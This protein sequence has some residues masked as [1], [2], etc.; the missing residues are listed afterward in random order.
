MRFPSPPP[1]QQKPIRS[2]IPE[3]VRAKLEHPERVTRLLF[4]FGIAGF[5]LAIIP[6]AILGFI[7]HPWL[8]SFGI[9]SMLVWIAI[10]AFGWVGFSLGFT[11]GRH[12]IVDALRSSEE[13]V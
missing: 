13:Q 10:A 3:A 6:S 11:A 5:F 4:A 8:A 1:L 7:F 2:S 12:L 9:P